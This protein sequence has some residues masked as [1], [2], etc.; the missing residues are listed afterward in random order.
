MWY[1]TAKGRESMDRF[2]SA[3]RLR[4]L[5]EQKITAEYYNS[6]K[7]RFGRVQV[8]VLSYLYEHKHARV[9]ELAEVLNIPKQHASKILSRLEEQ[10]YVSGKPDPDDG[11][12]NLYGLNEE[13]LSMMEQH[14]A[15]SNHCFAQ[16]LEKLSPEER[17]T[18]HSA[19]QTVAALLEKL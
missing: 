2:Q 15:V 7:G 17:E 9:Q 1:D 11:R 18:M 19:M 10:G 8:E 3:Y 4:V 16:R 13:G 6:F 14:L 12:S 5:F